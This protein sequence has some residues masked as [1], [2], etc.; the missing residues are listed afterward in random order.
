MKKVKLVSILL[1]VLLALTLCLTACK[2]ATPL[3]QEIRWN[4]N[5]VHV[6]Y[7][8]GLQGDVSAESNQVTFDNKTFV[9]DFSTTPAEYDRV[10]PIA[11]E[12][13]YTVDLRINEETNTVDYVTE[14]RVVETYDLSNVYAEAFYNYVT[15]TTDED[16]SFLKAQRTSEGFVFISYFYSAVCFANDLTMKPKSSMQLI[17]GYYIG[18]SN[19]EVNYLQYK[20]EYADGKATVTT[21]WDENAKVAT[22]EVADN[23]LDALQIPLVVRSLDQSKSTTDGKFVAPSVAVYDFKTN[24]TVTLNFTVASQTYVVLDKMS[25]T[26]PYAV[27][28]VVTVGTQGYSGFLY[29]F[30]S[31]N[32]ARD[33]FSSDVGPVNKYTQVRFQSEYYTYEL[34]SYTSDQVEDLKY[35]PAPTTEN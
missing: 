12:G 32:G 25:A 15:T 18:K 23:V 29:T 9:R 35:V 8:I 34:S 10:K 4:E 2:N 22:Y 33:T 1:V 27:A 14:Q 16:C 21:G 26:H 31:I 28:S 7:S 20:T 11:V 6:T 19:Y 30:T 3:S 5:E 13:T 24:K 17:G